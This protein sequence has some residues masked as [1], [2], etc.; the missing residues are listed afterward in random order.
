MPN[1][2]NLI[3]VDQRTW[4]L[5]LLDHPINISHR[6]LS[7]DFQALENS[8]GVRL[9]IQSNTFFETILYLLRFFVTERTNIDG[10]SP[11]FSHLCSIMTA[12][13][14]IALFWDL[15]S[16][17]ANVLGTES[18]FPSRNA[19]IGKSWKSCERQSLNERYLRCRTIV[20]LEN[21]EA[22]NLNLVKHFLF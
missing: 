12:P 17:F 20:G 1:Y 18:G 15:L 13:P 21:W 6:N 3:S 16:I 19:L 11:L 4:Y 7:N 5:R 2:F 9:S 8:R 22:S 14:V 10:I